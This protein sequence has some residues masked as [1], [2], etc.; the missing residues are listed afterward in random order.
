MALPNS[1]SEIR[2]RHFFQVHFYQLTV[3]GH[4]A[5]DFDFDI[6]GLGIDGSG[7]AFRFDEREELG[8]QI[9]VGGGQRARVEQQRP[10]PA[11]Q[12]T[13]HMSDAVKC[14]E[15][16][17]PEPKLARPDCALPAVR[18]MGRRDLR[19]ARHACPRFDFSH[20]PLV[21]ESGRL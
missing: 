11:K 14:F 21:G 6:G 17:L 12:P 18:A 20:G 16:E 10:E 2:R 13:V 8:D 1:A 4:Q 19:T 7:K 15:K 9:E 3:I 5:V